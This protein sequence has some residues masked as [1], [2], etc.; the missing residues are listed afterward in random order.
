MAHPNN[1]LPTAARRLAAGRMLLDGVPPAQV[2]QAM[3][4][5]NAKVEKYRH[6]LEKGGL[7]A[8]RDV[9][10]AGRPS[11]LDAEDRAWLANRPCSR[12]PC[13]LQTP[14]FRLPQTLL[15]AD[16]RKK[17]FD[18]PSLDIYLTMHLKT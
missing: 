8:L 12:R 14:P 15:S 9:S 4:V 2:E 3:G 1:D 17:V 7:D 11:P 16:I 5:K 13:P 6:L 18:K 10:V